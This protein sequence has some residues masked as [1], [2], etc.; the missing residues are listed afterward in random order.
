MIKVIKS[1]EYNANMQQSPGT[2]TE[3]LRLSKP[4][5]EKVDILI[6][7][8]FSNVFNFPPT[9]LDFSSKPL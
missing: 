5:Y 8:F 2:F 3:L 7:F 6:V 4:A 1:V 9:P